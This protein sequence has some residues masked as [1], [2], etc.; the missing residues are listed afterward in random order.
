MSISRAELQSKTK[1]NLKRTLTSKIVEF[2]GKDVRPMEVISGDG[3]KNLAQCLVEIGAKHGNIDVKT[4]LP[5][6]TTVSR[7]IIDVKNALHEE[8]FSMIRNAMLNS[9]C[10]AT[11][12]MWTDDFKKNSFISMTV[13]FF[14]ENFILKKYLLFTSLFG[15]SGEA[16][17]KNSQKTGENIKFELIKQFEL[18]GYDRGFLNKI[19]FV[20]DCGSNVVLALKEYH[21]DD[22]RAHR[23]NTILQNTFDSDDLPLVITKILKICKKIVQYLKESGK[24]NLLPKAAIQECGTRW[25]TKL[26]VL[27]SVVEQ[28]DEIK[29]ILTVTQRNKWYINVDIAAEIIRF[30]TPFKEATESLEGETYPT[31]CKVLLWWDNLSKHLNEENFSDNPIK[32][33]ARIAKM[34]FDLKFQVNMDNKIACF[35]DPRYRFL[36][37]LSENDRDDVH[38]EIKRLLKEV[39]HVEETPDL[40]TPR[41]KYR[42]SMFEENSK[43]F[44]SDNEFE[45]YMQSASF[46]EYYKT[47]ESK[48]HLVESFWRDNKE[49]FPKLYYLA[50]K[51][52]HVPATSAPSE[53]VFSSAGRIYDNKRTNLKPKKLDDLLFLKNNIKFPSPNM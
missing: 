45:L 35:L 30:L 41:K 34:Y 37:M 6:P 1:S 22:C 15:C 19:K 51:R 52:L 40:E 27:K 39:T 46:S 44:Q 43:D 24:T 9:E 49:R 13:H 38:T 7:H 29:K 4:I 31:A 10:S 32:T 26:G 17:K 11:T 23:L 25:N 33:L 21:R 2:C 8:L 3:F 5:H 16:T 53:V 47:E 12:D 50:K 20:T 48:K 14:D 42:F 36:K 28:Y 18:L